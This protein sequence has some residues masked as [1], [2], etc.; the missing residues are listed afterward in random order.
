MAS[1]LNYDSSV[2]R[3]QTEEAGTEAHPDNTSSEMI[4]DEYEEEE[5]DSNS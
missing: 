5:I 1:G 4:F 2:R 3:L